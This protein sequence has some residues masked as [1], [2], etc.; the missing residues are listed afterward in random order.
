M[1]S[2]IGQAV[3]EAGRSVDFRLL[4]LLIGVV[5]MLAEPQKAI[6]PSASMSMVKF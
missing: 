5:V 3:A 1:T 6:V 2:P 4:S